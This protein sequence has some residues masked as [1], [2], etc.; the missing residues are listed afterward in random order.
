MSDEEYERLE[1]H[2]QSMITTFTSSANVMEQLSNILV[3]SPEALQTYETA[4]AF[5]RMK[6]THY[7]I[8][9]LSLRAM[10]G[11][12]GHEW[13]T[14]PL[15]IGGSIITGLVADNVTVIGFAND[16]LIPVAIAGTAIA[17]VT[18]NYEAIGASISNVWSN[19]WS[20]SDSRDDLTVDEGQERIT[21]D[22]IKDLHE[23][24]GDWEEVGKPQ[25]EPA[26][27]KA[28]K[29]GTSVERT[30]ENT[31]TVETLKEHTVYGPNGQI[32]HGPH[33]R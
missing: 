32:W 19:L 10:H 11:N 12:R 21:G 18:T 15:L 4:A 3:Y 24:P 22:R 29:G 17:V 9:L 16:A 30:L 6:V 20:S 25:I 1:E 7:E 5:Y 31:R 26:T 14:K 23:N 8:M 27:G 13:N 28:Y 33:Y 2:Y